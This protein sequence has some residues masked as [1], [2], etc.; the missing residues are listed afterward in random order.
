MQNLQ[1]NNPMISSSNYEH[2]WL[3]KEEENFFTKDT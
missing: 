1:V 3:K 2:E